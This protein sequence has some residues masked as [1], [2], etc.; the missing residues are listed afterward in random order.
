M[1]LPPS[2]K[3]PKHV[4]LMNMKTHELELKTPFAACKSNA[5]KTS[6]KTRNRRDKTDYVML[7]F[8]QPKPSD[9]WLNRAVAWVDGPFSHV[10]LGFSDGHA[11][12]I[13]GGE[14]VFMKKRT[15]ANLQYSMHSIAMST[16]EVHEIRRFCHAAAEAEVGFDE[17][18]MYSVHLAR[19]L[20]KTIL[21]LK[22]VFGF[23]FSSQDQ[24]RGRR[25]S[26][27]E[28]ES[29]LVVPLK[30]QRRD[31]M[32]D[33][34]MKDHQGSRDF[35]KLC[36]VIEKMKSEGTFC[37]KLVTLALQHAGI[38]EFAHLD[39]SQTSP[40]TLY[41]L[42]SAEAFTSEVIAAAPYRQQLLAARPEV[43]LMK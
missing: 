19:P 35:V 5:P 3:N 7:M 14:K 16:A 24:R 29:H 28:R 21:G 37:S 25:K 40:S 12:S 31:H 8:Y 30:N 13:F 10:E 33:A 15:F 39:A 18:G 6:A 9:P 26:S 32:N 27:M 23:M 41:R 34:T 1:P 36:E 43:C 2:P 38:E 4:L 22:H 11:C 17:V 42:V 20:A